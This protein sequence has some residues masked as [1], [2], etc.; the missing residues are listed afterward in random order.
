MT[1]TQEVRRKIGS[2]SPIQ[3]AYRGFEH[4]LTLDWV[5]TQIQAAIREGV[6]DKPV[7]E[8]GSG[9][10]PIPIHFGP[11]LIET[12]KFHFDRG[13]RIEV[14]RALWNEIDGLLGVS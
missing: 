7:H 12:W 4:A 8:I 9:Q 3:V 6:L 11:S 1:N 13:H 10:V 5:H 14:S 2:A